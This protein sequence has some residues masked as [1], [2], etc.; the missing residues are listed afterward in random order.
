S[1]GTA[2]KSDAVPDVL[3]LG[4]AEGIRTPDLLSAIQAR[5]QLRHSP[6]RPV[7]Y[8][9][10]ASS[11]KLSRHG[12]DVCDGLVRRIE[13]DPIAGHRAPSPEARSDSSQSLQFKT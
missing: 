6:K 5:S 10:L 2:P 8:V 3:L 12:V 13:D 7:V 11:V 1:S 9:R 4:G